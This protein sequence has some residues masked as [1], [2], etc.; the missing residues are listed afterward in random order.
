[1]N[2]RISRVHLGILILVVVLILLNNGIVNGAESQPK[3]SKVETPEPTPIPN[4]EKSNRSITSNES[5]QPVIQS[6]ILDPVLNVVQ[7]SNNSLKWRAVYPDQN[8]WGNR[9]E[10]WNSVIGWKNITPDYY[11]KNGEYKSIDLP[12]GTYVGRLTYISSGS[13]VVVDKYIELKSTFDGLFYSNSINNLLLNRTNKIGEGITNDFDGNGNVL[14]KR[15]VNSYEFLSS[16]NVELSTPSFDV[17]ITS[18]PSSVKKLEIPTWSEINGQDD[19]EWILAEKVDANTWRGTIKFD[20]H[21]DNTGN[22]FIHVYADGKFIKGTS[23]N[24]VPSRVSISAPAGSNNY[25]AE[26]FVFANNVDQN[27]KEVKFPTWS[28]KND[29]DDILWIDGIKVDSTTW[30]ALVT[31]KNH[32]LKGTDR[33]ITDIYAYDRFGTSKKIGSASTFIEICGMRCEY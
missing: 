15:K 27:V 33:I 1:M 19:L 8:A 9:L 21:G 22:Y 23:L 26:Y 28:L 5:V 18:V 14:K 12:S 25:E 6:S 2:R 4:L 17:V 10:L 31:I 29:Q 7:T 16:S 32:V 30:K 3:P 11:T 20:K 24:V 13:W